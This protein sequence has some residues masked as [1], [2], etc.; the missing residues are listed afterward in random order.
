MCIR[1]ENATVGLGHL[2]T[3]N[4]IYKQ[5]NTKRLQLC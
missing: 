1:N 2:G 4:D 3:H 5:Y